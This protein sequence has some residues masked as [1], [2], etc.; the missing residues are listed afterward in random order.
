M[1]FWSGVAKGAR[2]AKNTTLVAGGV[3]AGVTALGIMASSSRG[4]RARSSAREIDNASSDLG[5]D[6]LP[7]VMQPQ[8]LAPPGPAEGY[9]PNQ[10]QNLVQVGRGG[11][12]IAA[13]PT[14]PKMNVVPEESVQALNPTR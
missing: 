5:Q 2:I 9:A 10:W 13:T 4:H 14:N 6:N 8:D 12:P 7:P 1:G 11:Q 3:V